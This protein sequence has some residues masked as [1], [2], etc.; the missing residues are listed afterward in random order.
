MWSY[1]AAT[2]GVANFDFLPYAFM[3]LINPVYAIVISYMGIGIKYVDDADRVS[4]TDEER[5]AESE[6]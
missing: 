1:Q 3:N 5:T 2:L 6:E 4:E